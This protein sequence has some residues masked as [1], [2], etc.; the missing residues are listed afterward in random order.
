[1]RVDEFMAL[2]AGDEISGMNGDPGRVVDVS[3]NR[4]VRTVHVQ[5]SGTGPSFAFTNRQNVWMHWTRHT[6]ERDTQAPD[7]EG[8]KPA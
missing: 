5:W 4:G 1:M 6:P 7:P 2:D 3:E 8:D